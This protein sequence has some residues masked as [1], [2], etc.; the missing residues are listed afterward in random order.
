MAAKAFRGDRVEIVD[1]LPDGEYRF[2][3][4]AD[5][6][7]AAGGGKSYYQCPMC[8]KWVSGSPDVI[9]TGDGGVEYCAN[10]KEQL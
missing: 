5:Y 1:D 3:K 2:F 10:C 6:K 4:T 8:E 7:R 9:D